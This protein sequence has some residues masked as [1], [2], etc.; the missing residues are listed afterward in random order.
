[1]LTLT[2]CDVY[3]GDEVRHDRAVVVRGGLIADLVPFDAIPEGGEMVDLGGASVVPGFV[4]LQV[5]GG[6]DRLFND[7]PSPETIEVIVAAHRRFGTTDLLPTF[8]TG[9]EEMRAK[10]IAA[11]GSC[12]EQGVPGVLGIHLEGP[13]LNPE[14]AGVHDPGFMRRMSHDDLG[15]LPDFGGVVLLTLAPEVV[16]AGLIAAAVERGIKV[17]AGHTNALFEQMVEAFDEGLDCG[18]HLFNAMRNI[19][20]REPGV[21]GAILENDRI[22]CGVIADCFHVHPASLRVAWQANGRGRTFLVTDAMP[23]VGGE[24]LEFQIGS[25]KAEVVEGRCQTP[26]GVLAGS[27]LDMASAVRNTVQ[28]LGLPKDEALRMASLYPAAYVGV[29]DRLG[30]IAPGYHANLT[31]LDTEM[32]VRGVM[33]AGKMEWA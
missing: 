20:S 2:N 25:Q 30:R 28:R 4:D 6:G 22:C 24:L 3:S 15:Q 32:Y 1:M 27:A 11:V 29:D 12:L 31:I 13:F 8:I 10:A 21:V 17:S 7:D 33:V 9:S 19:E 18:T 26:E 5:N 16:E 23:P 14:K